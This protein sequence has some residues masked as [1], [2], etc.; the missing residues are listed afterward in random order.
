MVAKADAKEGWDWFASVG[1]WGLYVV[2]GGSLPQQVVVARTSRARF[3]VSRD[4]VVRWACRIQFAPGPAV[5]VPG[6]VRGDCSWP[7]APGEASRVLF[8]HPPG[9]PRHFEMYK[10][11]DSP[12]T[13]EIVQG[14]RIS[15][16]DEGVRS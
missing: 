16:L 3:P 1:V 11:G 8:S 7:R 5:S 6:Q 10:K 13:L 2:A 14:L 4:P 15:S 9:I 12:R